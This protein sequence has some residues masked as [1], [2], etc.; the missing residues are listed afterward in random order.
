M[1]KPKNI[2][3]KIDVAIFIS[4]RGS[5]MQEIINSCEEQSFPARVQLV[6]SNNPNAQGLEFARNKKINTVIINH[7]NFN[8]KAEFESEII[9]EL[10]K[11]NIKL[12]CLAGFMRVLSPFFINKVQ[13][14]LI[15]IHPSLLPDFKGANAVEDAIKSKAKISGCTTHFVNAEVDG[16]EIIMQKQVNIEDYDDAETL[17]RKILA[18]EHKIYPE[19]LFLVANQLI[20]NSN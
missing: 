9:A 1:Q 7:S 15:N 14:P 3:K 6:I 18:L 4:G 5:N 17:A 16:G 11:N 13:I 12:V 10:N 2:G 8:S 19:T 20:N